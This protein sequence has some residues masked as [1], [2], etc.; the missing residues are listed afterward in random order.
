MDG[1]NGCTPANPKCFKIAADYDVVTSKACDGA[2]AAS[3]H[4]AAVSAACGAEPAANGAQPRQPAL[5]ALSLAPVTPGEDEVSTKH[6]LRLT[7]SD[8][9][10]EPTIDKN[11][12][13]PPEDDAE[14]GET[15]ANAEA[16]AERSNS[17]PK[18]AERR[19]SCGDG[20]ETE[21]RMRAQL[22]D[23]RKMVRALVGE[24]AARDVE[25]YD[26]VASGDDDEDVQ[27]DDEDGRDQGD[28]FDLTKPPSRSPSRA[29]QFFR[30][31][32]A[33]TRHP[34]ALRQERRVVRL[35]QQLV[36]ARAERDSLEAEMRAERAEWR[37]LEAEARRG[38]E[39]AARSVAPEAARPKA[40][41]RVGGC[42][43]ADARNEKQMIIGS[44][45]AG[46]GG[47]CC[48][49]G[50]SEAL[51]E[52][53]AQAMMAQGEVYLVQAQLERTEAQLV[54]VQEERRKE[55]ERHRGA[56]KQF[57]RFAMEDREREKGRAEEEM[58]RERREMEER[59]RKEMGGLEEEVERLRREVEKGRERG[60]ERVQEAWERGRKEGAGE[61]EFMR[62]V[63]GEG[64]RR[65][66]ELRA[67]VRQLEQE[68]GEVERER[69]E[70]DAE[71]REWEAE[72]RKMEG[73]VKGEQARRRAV[74]AALRRVEREVV[75]LRRARGAVEGERRA[76][77]REV[78]KEVMR[79]R[80]RVEKLE[81]GVEGLTGEV[82]ELKGD[83]E[84][85]K[86]G[87]AQRAAEA[88]CYENAHKPTHAHRAAPV[89]MEP[90]QVPPRPAAAKG[91]REEMEGQ[92]WV[93]APAALVAMVQLRGLS[94][95]G[96][97]ADIPAAAAA[98]A[99][100]ARAQA[101]GVCPISLL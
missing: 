86:S 85:L 67:R 33:R 31:F 50:G 98:A 16:Q 80:E 63:I 82:G 60:R 26:D 14:K 43:E 89:C 49:C 46:S 96:D 27:E 8:C 19:R 92:Q 9:S 29:S 44:E 38:R 47:G 70:W 88:A 62:K 13:S 24:L 61:A 3:A 20:G 79:E 22:A 1:E 39:A 30:R 21:E 57:V 23:A 18:T 65:V 84:G 91:R 45:Q 90:K 5:S 59:R 40:A 2:D 64:E 7:E 51:E 94:C 37:A 12:N 32:P 74:E 35:K 69:S 101:V 68:K 83:V 55:R 78:Q 66:G 10:P 25:G 34:Q 100:W 6:R 48:C 41:Q 28:E 42:V 95:W 71:R 54:R 93:A 81:W 56:L 97:L 72:R 15:C 36:R 99:A 52:L 73:E 77:V 17:T 58:G 4:G 75:E 11:R 53:Q 87:E 76:V